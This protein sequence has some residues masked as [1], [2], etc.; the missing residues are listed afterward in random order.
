VINRSGIFE[1]YNVESD[2]RNDRT[3]EN[4]KLIKLH[5]PFYRVWQNSNE[6]VR[7]LANSLSVNTFRRHPK[8]SLWDS[9]EQ[10]AT[11]GLAVSTMMAKSLVYNVTFSVQSLSDCLKNFDGRSRRHS[12]VLL[13]VAGVFSERTRGEWLYCTLDWLLIK[14]AFLRRRLHRATCPGNKHIPRQWRREGVCPPPPR[15]TSLLQTL[16]SPQSD[17]QLIFLWLQRWH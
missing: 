5:R 17:L 7:Q 4:N 13:F 16:S 9:E 12:N 6:F 10:H 1:R 14:S 8:A 2:S 3:Q 11:S 15:G